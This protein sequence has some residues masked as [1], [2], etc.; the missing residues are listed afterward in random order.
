MRK[1]KHRP[2]QQTEIEKTRDDVKWYF[3]DLNKEIMRDEKVR[4]KYRWKCPEEFLYLEV[5]FVGE[6]PMGP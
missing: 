2:S 5:Q 3:E 6:V 1:F 4:W